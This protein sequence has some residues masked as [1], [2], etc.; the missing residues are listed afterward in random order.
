MLTV[1]FVGQFLATFSVVCWVLAFDCATSAVPRCHQPACSRFAAVYST[2][3]HYKLSLWTAIRTFNYRCN[4]TKSTVL[5]FS[6]NCMQYSNNT[7]NNVTSVIEARSTSTHLLAGMC[8]L[9]VECYYNT[10]L[11]LRLFF[12]I[13][14]GITR[15]LCAMHVFEVWASSS[16]SRLPLC[17]ILFLSWSPFKIVPEINIHS[18]WINY[19]QTSIS[20]LQQYHFKWLSMCFICFSTIIIS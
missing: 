7:T 18:N 16:S 6:T 10:L 14:C 15:F 19:E 4:A 12:I 13:E 9:L 2:S 17:Q 11:M 5:R 20:Y 3:Q 8:N 1:G